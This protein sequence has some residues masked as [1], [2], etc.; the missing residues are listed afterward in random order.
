MK[1]DIIKT[2]EYKDKR[3]KYYEDN[4]KNSYKYKEFLK[5][6]KNG[7]FIYLIPKIK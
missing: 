6:D 1:N 5:I 3:S 4:F 7:K 2:K